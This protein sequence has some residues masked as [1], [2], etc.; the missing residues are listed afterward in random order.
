MN[1]ERTT[2]FL[3]ANLGSEMMRFF[4]LI[5]QDNIPFAQKSAERVLKIIDSIKNR[6]DIKGGK[7]EVEIL[8]SITLD[9]LND[10]H[11][12][13]VSEKELNSYFLPFASRAILK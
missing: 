6:S 7:E 9:A 2:N 1:T 12:F 3:M 10:N 8:K 11:G 4:G 5:K 13:N